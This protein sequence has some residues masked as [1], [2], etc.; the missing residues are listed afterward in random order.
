MKT[1]HQLRQCQTHIVK[2]LR[3]AVKRLQTVHQHDLSVEPQKMIFIEAFDHFFAVIAVAFAQHTGVGGFVGLRQTRLAN[4][5]YVRPG[6]KL[7]RRRARHIAGQ[8]EA[9]W[10][11]KVQPFTFT[12]V[13]I[14][15]PGFGNRREAVF[16]GGR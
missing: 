11:D 1:L 16:I 8:H 4:G 14:I 3:P 6:E 9:A 7:Q 12:G 15:G 5:V 13:Q 2:C 10:L